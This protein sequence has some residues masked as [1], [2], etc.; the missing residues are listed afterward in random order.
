MVA[1]FTEVIESEVT[2]ICR[3]EKFVRYLYRL[4]KRRENDPLVV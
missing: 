4:E 1:G 3:V 2:E